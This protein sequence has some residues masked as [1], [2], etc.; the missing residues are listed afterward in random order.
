MKDVTWVFSAW[1]PGQRVMM[2]DE[3]AFHFKAPEWGV[4]PT[5]VEWRNAHRGH[6]ENSAP[7]MRPRALPWLDGR[8]LDLGCGL[9]KIVLEDRCI[10]VDAG[11]YQEGCAADVYRDIT[12]LSCYSDGE[13][14][15]VYS[16]NVLEHIEDWEDAL[17]EWVR[18][19]RVGGV[20]FLCVPWPERCLVQEAGSTQAHVWNP[21]PFILRGALSRLGVAI[22]EM[23][24]DVDR[25]G[26][27][28]IVGVK[29]E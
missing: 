28:C 2:D 17:R 13:F 6:R 12:D 26:C 7:F 5:G 9:E 20:V 3:G 14:D 15:W 8:G 27:F 11:G 1:V 10:G 16:S 22:A 18:V 21:S 23:D 25:W 4:T 19:V 29:Q 24:S